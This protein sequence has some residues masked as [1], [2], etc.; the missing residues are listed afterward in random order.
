VPFCDALTSSLNC[1]EGSGLMSTGECVIA[2]MIC[3]C[4]ACC[5][6]P[7]SKGTPLPVS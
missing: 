4:T 2:W 6:G 1:L 5:S 7:H 3:S